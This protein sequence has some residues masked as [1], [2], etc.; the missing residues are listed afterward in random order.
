MPAVHDNGPS[1]LRTLLRCMGQTVLQC[2]ALTGACVLAALAL[3]DLK[4]ACAAIIGAVTAHVCA[5]LA[6]YDSAAMRDGLH[7]FNGVLSAIAAALFI[8]DTQIALAVALLSAIAAT[9]LAA[10]LSRR[11]G[12]RGLAVYS[13]PCIAVTWGWMLLRSGAHEAVGH[14]AANLDL[15]PLYAQAARIR[16]PLDVLL[17]T[18]H[19]VQ[20]PG[21]L[22]DAFAAVA[23]TVFASGTVPGLLIAA[24]IALAS[25][26]AALY[27]LVGGVTSS[28]VAW[29]CGAPIAALHTGIAGFNG[30]L[31]ALALVDQGTVAAPAAAILSA[32]LQQAVAHVG[33]P[34]MSAPFVVAVWCVRLCGRAFERGQPF[35]H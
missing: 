33:W 31:A 34:T 11:L 27:A 3:C 1:A 12:A 5:I 18:G 10:P 16:F 22:G 8:D 13:S 14:S 35:A 26:R 25:R 4:L 23:Q 9:C 24:G 21:G 15:G 6:N 2:N 20:L 28:A 30:A 7:G 32:L 17:G 29:L 19:A